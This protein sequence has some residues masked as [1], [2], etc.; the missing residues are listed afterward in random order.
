VVFAMLPDLPWTEI[1]AIVCRAPQTMGR[2]TISIVFNA[3]EV[4]GR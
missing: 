3:L 4:T 2:A 1:R